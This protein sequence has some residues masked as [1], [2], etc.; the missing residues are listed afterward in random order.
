LENELERQ[1]DGDEP[2]PDDD[3]VSGMPEGEP[4]LTPMGVDPVAS[5]E[6]TSDDPPLPGFPAEDEPDVSG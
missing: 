4:E 3:T 5:D 2:E 6:D 1:P